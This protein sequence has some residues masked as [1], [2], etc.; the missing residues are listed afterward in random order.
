MKMNRLFWF[1]ALLPVGL[2]AMFPSLVAN[3]MVVHA[4]FLCLLTV[5]AFSGLV[6]MKQNHWLKPVARF[7]A[8]LKM[9]V[10]IITALGVVS[11][12]GT[13]VESKYNLELA[14]QWV[15]QSAWMWA[16]MIALC[17]NLIGVMAD[18]YPWKKKH[19][20]FLF[21]HV[22][23]LLLLIGSALTYRFGVDGTMR[24]VIGDK[25]NYVTLT[26]TDLVIWS[27]FDGQKYTKLFEQEV[28]FFKLKPTRDKPFLVSVGNQQIEIVDF[29]PFAL[30]ER[31]FKPSQSERS[32][33]VVRLQLDN[34]QT[35]FT[36]YVF[37]RARGGT[38]KKSLGPLDIVLTDS[39]SFTPD[40]DVNSLVLKPG[41]AEPSKLEALLY[42]KGKLQTQTT[43][44]EGSVFNTGWMGL[45]LRILRYLPQAEESI[46]VQGLS[47]PNEQTRPTVRV[48][49]Q[50]GEESWLQMNSMLK[51]FQEN[52]VTLVSFAN[53][54]VPLGFELF[55]EE[56]K[57]GRYEG[58]TKAASYESQVLVNGKDSQLISMNKP[59]YFNGYKVYQASF[60]EDEDGQAVASIFSVNFDPG[61]ELKYLGSLLIVLGAFFLFYNRRTVVAAAPKVR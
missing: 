1:L 43:L 19:A 45:N 49:T 52:S 53:R 42:K 58:T 60:E 31:K 11:A 40:S 37:L 39:E 13:V 59:L 4:L 15:Y 6:L 33:A 10:L 20:A 9:A 5:S 56:F 61:L 25:N 8:S 3:Q 24:V 48:R 57:V 51:L 30:A 50:A 16:P 34:D 26:P 7:F 12:V 32:G 29:V 55:L 36:D 27:S 18:R 38:E 28:D 14:Q 21:A 46:E 44:A 22:G 17:V 47:Y 23:I 54:R 41:A 35:S 2:Y